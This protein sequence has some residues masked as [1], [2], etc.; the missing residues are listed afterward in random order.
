MLAQISAEISPLK[1]KILATF[2]AMH[3]CC[4]FYTKI[5]SLTI[6]INEYTQMFQTRVNQSLLSCNGKIVI[7]VHFVHFVIF[8]HFVQVTVGFRM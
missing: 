5:V 2:P 1:P 6:Q 4:C 3:A 8:V 7:I